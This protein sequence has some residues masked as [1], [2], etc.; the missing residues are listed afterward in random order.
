MVRGRA[1]LQRPQLRL[2][3]GDAGARLTDLVSPAA[4]REINRCHNP[5]PPCR[6]FAAL[7]HFGCPIG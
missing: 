1:T 7:A 4:P 2:A 6:D 3:G 5:C